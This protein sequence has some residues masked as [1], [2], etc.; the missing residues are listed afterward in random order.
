[1]DNLLEQH[2]TI[3]CSHGEVATNIFNILIIS[4][5]YLINFKVLR[6]VL[7]QHKHYKVFFLVYIPHY[8]GL[9]MTINGKNSDVLILTTL[10]KAWHIKLR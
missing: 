2:L 6:I 5:E 4:E 3:Y 9:F 7:S 10:N 1:M 8:N